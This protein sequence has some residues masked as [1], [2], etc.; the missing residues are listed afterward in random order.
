MVLGLDDHV[1]EAECLAAQCKRIL[2]ARR[3]LAEAEGADNRVDLVG[4]AHDA[5]CRRLRLAVAGK[6]RLVVLIDGDGDLLALAVEL[7]V[8]AAH[9]AL[10]FREL[11]NHARDEVGL[12]ED[13]RAARV[14]VSLLVGADG[15]G[16][17]IG[18]LL[19][20]LRLLVHRAEALLEDDRLELL[21]VLL[22]A[23]LAVFIEEELR[24][25]ETGA[26]DALIAVLDRLEVFLAAVADRDEERQQLALGRLDREVALMVAHRCDDG[27]RRQLQVLLLELAAERRRVL[28][29]VEDLF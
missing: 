29:E 4:Q 22:E 1:D 15:I 26:Q 7:R 13:G 5:A 3:D 17:E 6:A 24:I 19:K 16:D 10:Q 21:A 23:L 11:R 25:G 2:R 20:A 28:D 27:L 12:R 9:D 8:L 14:L 18:K